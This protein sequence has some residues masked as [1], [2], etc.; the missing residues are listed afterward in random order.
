[1]CARKSSAEYSKQSRSKLTV[2]QKRHLNQYYTRTWKAWIGRHVGSA[3]VEDRIKQRPASLTL[4]SITN[5]FIK[6]DYKCMLTGV[7]LRHDKSLYSMSIDRID[8]SIGHTLDNIQ[9]ISM[10]LNLAK[11]RHSNSDLQCLLDNLID[12]QFSPIKFSRD[13]LSTC[14][15]N[16]A[17]RKQCH[18][19]TDDIVRIWEA[20]DGRCVLTGIKLAA[21]NHP[22]FAVSMDRI[23]HTDNYSIDNVRLVIKSINLARGSRTDSELLEWLETTK[24]HLRLEL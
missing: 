17:L 15:R 3:L 4:E 9:L 14:R 18:L 1:M 21:Y 23:D 8:N 7:P 2:E 22:M 11:N 10:G 6:I 5:L 19:T 13:Y 12:D 24:N 20:Q 16:A